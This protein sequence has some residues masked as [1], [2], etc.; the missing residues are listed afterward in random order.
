M[1]EW[2]RSCCALQARDALST[3]NSE[4]QARLAEAHA[5]IQ[6]V[7]AH[8]AMIRQHNIGFILEQMNTMGPTSSDV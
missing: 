7:Q 1:C 5:M 3:E 8:I 2:I 6:E 4:L